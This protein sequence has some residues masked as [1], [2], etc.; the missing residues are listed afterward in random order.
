MWSVGK[1]WSGWVSRSE[2]GVVAPIK[3]VPVYAI[4][5]NQPEGP[6]KNTRVDINVLKEALAL[7]GI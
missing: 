7:A 6:C 3:N 2:E 1:V 5:N 4:I